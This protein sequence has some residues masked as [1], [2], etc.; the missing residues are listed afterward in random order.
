MSV[1]KPHASFTLEQR[2]VKESQ[3]T[4]AITKRSMKSEYV[5]V[6][7]LSHIEMASFSKA[8]RIVEKTQEALLRWERRACSRG[9]GEHLWHSSGW[10]SP[11]GADD[12]TSGGGG[13]GS[14]GGDVSDSSGGGR[15]ARSRYDPAERAPISGRAQRVVEPTL[16]RALCPVLV[17]ISGALTGPPPAIPVPMPVPTAAP[18]P[19]ATR[20][21]TAL[22]KEAERERPSKPCQWRLARSRA[23]F[24]VR[25]IIVEGSRRC[26]RRLNI[27]KIRV[28][29]VPVPLGR[30]PQRSSLNSIPSNG[31]LSK[32]YT[33]AA[34]TT[35]TV[36]VYYSTPQPCRVP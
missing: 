19:T 18:R 16:S 36:L 13:G 35:I 32:F 7:V 11:C 17:G 1:F 23:Y 20:A 21:A 4:S 25:T 34:T 22:S 24:L 33:T 31:L 5:E 3:M 27:G 14:S 2:F 15:T 30:M 29:A 28:E 8:N 6:E 26:Y 12:D 9:V 10:R